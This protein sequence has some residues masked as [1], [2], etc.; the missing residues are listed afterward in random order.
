LTFYRYSHLRRLLSGNLTV[1]MPWLHLKK[2]LKPRYY[3]S[4]TIVKKLAATENLHGQCELGTGV[5]DRMSFLIPQNL[6]I[7]A[8]LL[9]L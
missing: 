1:L 7:L 9:P 2:Q 4:G 5:T 3:M 8:L 6:C